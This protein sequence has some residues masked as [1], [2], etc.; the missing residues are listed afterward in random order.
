LFI[1]LISCTYIS[2]A[3]ITTDP[4]SVPPLPVTRA[5]V[6]S[7][8]TTGKVFPNKV[9]DV[10]AGKSGTKPITDNIAD[11]KSLSKFYKA[12][13][14]A[15]LS[16]TFKSK[17]PVTLFA[18][19]DNAFAKISAGRLDTLL[20]PDHKPQLLAI[21]TYHAIAGKFN[22]R[23]LVRKCLNKKTAV[24]T[25]LGGGKLTGEI[26]A[27]HNIIFT[28][29]TGGKSMITKMDMEQSNGMLF[30]INTVLIP[31]DKILL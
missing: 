31:K 21:L 16:E 20:R 7:S 5:N 13:Q 14:V 9:D 25:T 29:E 2:F 22:S 28:D 3:Q 4:I 11:N 27:D 10:K 23:Q 17:G 6:N 1:C 12:V 26:D 18:P 8:L 19:D 30:V 15:G 24:F